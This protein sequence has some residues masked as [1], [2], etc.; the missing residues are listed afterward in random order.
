MKI[1][2]LNKRNL[3]AALD[4]ALASLQ[5]GGLVVIPTDT[6]YGLA[7]M[8]DNKSAINKLFK[9]KQ[10]DFGKPI[11]MLASDVG[12]LSGNGISLTKNEKKLADKY[13]PGPLTLVLKAGR[14]KEG[15]R[16]PDNEIAR[17][18]IRKAGG[19]LRVTSANIS[20]NCPAVTV[21]AAVKEL[22]GSVA[23]YLDAGR[24]RVGVASTVVEVKRGKPVIL[25]QGA[26]SAVDI[27]RTL[28]L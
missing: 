7:A 14:R 18:L 6:V 12:S 20:G 10:R 1:I 23:V 3:S 19:L 4:E 25:R 13:W 15:V 22:G 9:A 27:I 17:S 16:V 11:A 26:L 2:K 8:P 28:K 21:S 5:S 24:S